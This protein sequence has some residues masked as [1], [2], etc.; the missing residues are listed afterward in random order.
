MPGMKRDCGGAAA[1]MG[2]FYA[3]VKQVRKTI[4]NKG[5]TMVDCVK[6]ICKLF[7]QIMP[8]AV[9]IYGMNYIFG[10]G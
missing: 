6:Y 8:H 5:K 9:S 10:G 1:V 4:F 2:A 3:A 7:S